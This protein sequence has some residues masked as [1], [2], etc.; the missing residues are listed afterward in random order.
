MAQISGDRGVSD[1]QPLIEGYLGLITYT[2]EGLQ[3][4]VGYTSHILDNHTNISGCLLLKSSNPSCVSRPPKDT[5]MCAFFH[6]QMAY[7]LPRYF[8]QKM[9]SA[10][11]RD[12][13]SEPG[14]HLTC[15]LKTAGQRG[16]HRERRPESFRP[17]TA[18]AGE[19]WSI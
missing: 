1:T 11:G 4:H 13:H 6:E 10:M 5:A 14:R 19:M 8:C 15:R 12:H 2:L 17:L 9:Y 3:R 18:R 7:V 16:S